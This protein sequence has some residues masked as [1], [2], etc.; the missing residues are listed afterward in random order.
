MAYHNI[1][2]QHSLYCNFPIEFSKAQVAFA[3]VLGSFSFQTIGEKTED[4]K[5]I[6]EVDVTCVWYWT[7][8]PLPPSCMD[9]DSESL[10]IL[11]LVSLY[12]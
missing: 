8:S 7:F 12:G 2:M 11:H 1:S 5:L 10:C 4:E 3:G 6:G 9:N